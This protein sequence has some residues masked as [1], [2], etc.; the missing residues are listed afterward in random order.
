MWLL[1]PV[2]VRVRV[3]WHVVIEG[4]VDSLY[5]HP[6]PKQVCGHQDSP[7]EV[8]ELLV[9]RQTVPQRI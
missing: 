2:Q 7:L 4:D 9:A 6:S 5:V 8:L 3:L 1:Y